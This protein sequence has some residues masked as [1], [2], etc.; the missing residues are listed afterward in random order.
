MEVKVKKCATAS[1]IL[2][3]NRRRSSL[4]RELKFKGQPIPNLALAQPTKYIRTTVGA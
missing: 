4:E 1:S 3:R 2:D